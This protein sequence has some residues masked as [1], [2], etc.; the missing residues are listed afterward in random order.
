MYG[1]GHPVGLKTKTCQRV[2]EL[3]LSQRPSIIWCPT[4]SVDVLLQ[5]GYILL[6]SWWRDLHSGQRKTLNSPKP[7]NVRKSE[8]PLGGSTSCAA[9]LRRAALRM[10]GLGQSLRDTHSLMIGGKPWG[11][12]PGSDYGG[13]WQSGA[14]VS[15]TRRRSPWVNL[16]RSLR[17]VPGI[18]KIH[19]SIHS[20]HNT[21]LQSKSL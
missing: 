6:G 4:V 5:L 3:L 20:I 12:P 2:E 9:A 10:M 21:L 18:S 8:N 11:K 15:S 1:Y 14:E 13:V 7:T 16:R 17:V 19:S